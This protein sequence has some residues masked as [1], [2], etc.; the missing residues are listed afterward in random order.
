MVAIGHHDSGCFPQP[1]GLEV[2]LIR[3]PAAKRL[4]RSPGIV[5]G[6]VVSQSGRKQIN[7]ALAMF[8]QWCTNVIRSKVEPMKPVVSMIRNYLKGIVAWAQTR[9]TKGFLEVLNG[10]F[11]AAM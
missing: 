3:G 2:N 4:V 10:L 6:E 8:W 9:L 5:E 11:Q 1:A 7:V